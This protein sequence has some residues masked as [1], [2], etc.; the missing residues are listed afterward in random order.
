MSNI[1]STEECHEDK[2]QSIAH[3]IAATVLLLTVV[4]SAKQSPRRIRFKPGATKA[5]V[6]GRLTG[7]NDKAHYVIRLPQGRP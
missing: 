3:V 4:G 7:W 2:T 6:T 5:S 1:Y